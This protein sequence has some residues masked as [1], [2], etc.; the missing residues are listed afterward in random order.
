MLMETAQLTEEVA[1]AGGSHSGMSQTAYLRRDG[2]SC[3]PAVIL[4][5][6]GPSLQ[7]PGVPQARALHSLP[8]HLPG[9][10]DTWVT[11]SF[12][13]FKSLLTCFHVRE[14]QPAHLMD[15]FHPPSS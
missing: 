2:T 5:K 15:S 12:P 8:A 6:N 11:N 3:H 10:P 14:L 9:L 7:K 4:V 13:S 1:D